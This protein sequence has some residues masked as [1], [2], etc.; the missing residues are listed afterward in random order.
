[1]GIKR[2]NQNDIRNRNRKEDTMDMMRHICVTHRVY[3]NTKVYFTD[4]NPSDG[5]IKIT[6]DEL[7]TSFQATPFCFKRWNTSPIH[8]FI[9]LE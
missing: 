7:V 4:I 6:R 5:R 3:S 1:M 2:N 8:S 9:V